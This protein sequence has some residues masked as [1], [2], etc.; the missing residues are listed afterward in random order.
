[1]SVA[2]HSRRAR[3]PSDGIVLLRVL[4]GL[5]RLHG[6]GAFAFVGRCVLYIHIYIQPR[7]QTISL[8]HGTC[9]GEG[10]SG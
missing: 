6:R 5:E 4:G 3:T 8:P 7:P 2:I 10:S 9:L 1:M